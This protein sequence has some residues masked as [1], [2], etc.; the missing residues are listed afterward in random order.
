[1]R[2]CNL[3]CGIGGNRKLWTPNGDE[4]EITAVEYDP[5]IAEVYQDF[6]PNDKVIV[7]DAHQYL[8]D[9]FK[10]FDFIW[11]SPPCQTHSRM[12]Q[13]LQVKC[14]GQKTTYPDMRLYQEILL[15]E[16]NF[17]GRYVIENVVPYYKPLITPKIELHRHLFWCNFVIDK[18]TFSKSKL[19]S[20]QIP[21]LQKY[22][23]INLDKYTLKNKRQALRNCVLPEVGLHIL[24]SATKNIQE[25]LF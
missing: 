11:G 1:M 18:L 20:A 21:E 25:R 2:I 17:K 3:Y 22:H 23:G 24:D 10:E 16:N 6:F 13:F 7:G 4:H 8:L 19:R 9:H 12:R 5:K 14:R 15:L